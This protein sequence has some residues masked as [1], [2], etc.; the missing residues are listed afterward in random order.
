MRKMIL[1]LM[2]L[3]GISLQAQIASWVLHPTYDKIKPLNNGNYVVSKN[4]RQGMVNAQEQ[5][6]LP[7]QYDKVEFY[8]GDMGLLYNGNRF[9]GYTDD[10]G[11]ERLWPLLSHSQE[12]CAPW[13]I[14]RSMSLQRGLC[15]GESAEECQAHHG[16]RIHLRR[17]VGKDR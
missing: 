9:V 11:K 7:I 8:S 17:A 6:I 12:D 15:L 13:P 5:E 1:G 4:G 16:R 14:Q 10:Q 2:L 3:T